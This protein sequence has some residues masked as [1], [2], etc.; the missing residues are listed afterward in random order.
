[1]T[2]RWK[3]ARA[4]ILNIWE[5]DRQLYDFADG[6]LILR[7]PNGSG[8]SNALA[9]LVP[10]LLDGRTA[11]TAMDPFAGSRS[12][13]S[14]LLVPNPE[15]AAGRTTRHDSRRGYCWLELTRPATDDG[16]EERLVLGVGAQASAQRD[17]VTTWFFIARRSLGDGADLLGSAGVLSSRQ[18]ADVLGDRGTVVDTA[19]AY[20]D[21]LDRQLFGF[22]PDRYRRLVSLL[23]TLRRPKLAD[24]LHLDTLADALRAGLPPLDD[25]LLDEVA[26]TF[27]DLERTQAD[28][29]RAR[30]A[31]ADV[32][33]F[34]PTYAAALQ[35]EARSRAVAARVS[36]G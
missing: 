27:E 13:R 9:L 26:A 4:G 12:M 14:L 29:D 24:K 8:K 18:L 19:E 5:Y 1:M 11:A 32:D 25:Q 28:L 20:R 23:L 22:G 33:D 17:G 31:L 15:D 30:T 34:L 10:F 16:P 3:P 36:K 7:G 21:L 2:R 35:A 6:R